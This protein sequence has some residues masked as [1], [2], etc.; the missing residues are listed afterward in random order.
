MLYK[1]AVR[2]DRTNVVWGIC[3]DVWLQ[4]KVCVVYTTAVNKQTLFLYYV[5][6]L[7][8]VLFIYLFFFLILIISTQCS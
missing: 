5:T 1:L 6:F 7:V 3:I 2:K 4:G 8:L